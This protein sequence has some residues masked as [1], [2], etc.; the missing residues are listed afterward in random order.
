MWCGRGT[1]KR[2]ESTV[3]L[4]A[5]LLFGHYQGDIQND[6]DIQFHFGVYTHNDGK[7]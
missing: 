5:Y 7:H 2:K 4:R 1:G 6:H 3:L